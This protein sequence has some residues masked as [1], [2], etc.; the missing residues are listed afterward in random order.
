MWFIKGTKNNI[1]VDLGPPD[2]EQALENHGYV[3]KREKEQEPVNALKSIGLSPDDVKIVIVTHLHWDHA[4]G[5]HL[6][7]NA[8]FLIQRK[9]VEYAIAPLPCHRPIY[10]EKSLGKPQFVDYLEQIEPIDGDHEV[11]DGVKAIFIPSH[12]PGFQGVLV[13]TQKGN[14]FIAG[15]A[16]GLF[17]CWE[18]IPHVP[19]SIFNNLEQYYESI[20]RIEQIADFVLPGHDGRVFDKSVYP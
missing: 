17:E 4:L 20:E 10:Y 6:F 19:S 9:E 18:T 13:R 5:F 12:S 7:K 16:V 8:K 3:I 15:D 1:I 14:Y 2:P 11:E